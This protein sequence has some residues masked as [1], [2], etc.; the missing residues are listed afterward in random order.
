MPSTICGY[1]E[2]TVMHRICNLPVVILS[3]QRLLASVRYSTFT[4]LKDATLPKILP[5]GSFPES[6]KYF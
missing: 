2:S 6:Y 3:R 4:T 5:P 1:I